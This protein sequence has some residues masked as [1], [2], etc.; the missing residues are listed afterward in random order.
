MYLDTLDT[1]SMPEELKNLKKQFMSGSRTGN[2]DKSQ[3]G[4]ALLEEVNK[5]SKSWLKMAGIPSEK[6]W[7]RVF[8]NL[9]K[10]NEASMTLFFRSI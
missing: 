4:D 1:I 8:R 2:I 10:L 6:Q 7:L 5:D 3:G 9:D